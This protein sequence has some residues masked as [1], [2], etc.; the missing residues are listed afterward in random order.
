[1][2]GTIRYQRGPRGIGSVF[3]VELPLPNAAPPAQP[4][5]HAT[6]AQPPAGLR[7]LVV[8]DVAAN[9][10]L[11]EVLLQQAGYHVQLAADGEAA[12]AAVQAGPVP[13][14]VIMD[15]YMPG[16][17]GL[18]AT[19]RIRGLPGPAARVPIIA[20]TADASA[21]SA[22]TCRAAGMN[23]YITKPLDFVELVAAIR[24]AVTGDSAVPSAE[25]TGVGAHSAVWR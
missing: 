2:G 13:D 5:T 14:V 12:I 11:A 24:E 4:S 18:T 20:L 6:P 8:D 3:T 16:V 9:R 15:V 22:Q 19:Q 25:P 7:V 17:D 21:E 10:K 1:M 23:G